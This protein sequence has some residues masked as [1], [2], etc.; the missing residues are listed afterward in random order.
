MKNLRYILLVG[1]GCLIISCDRFSTSLYP[2]YTVFPKERIVTTQ[3]IFVDSVFFRYPY[4]ITIKDNIAIVM[5]LHNDSYFFH[6][7]TY[8]GWELIAPFGKRGEGPE[9]MLSAEMFQFCSADSIWAI[10]ANKMQITRWAISLTEKT[11]SRVEEIAL[12]KNLVRSLDFYRTDYVFLITDYLGNYRYH[13]VSHRGNIVRSIGKIPTETN[14]KQNIYPALAQAWR[15]FTDYNSQN[16]VYA[17]VTQLGE[18]LEIYDL[19]RKTN[20]IVYGPNGEPQFFTENGGECIPSGIKGFT[21]V[22]VTDKYIYAVFD[23]LSWKER[24]A[25]RQRGEIPPQ[26]GH[27][28]YTFDFNGEPIQKYILDKNILGIHIDETT[29]TCFATCVESDNPILTF[30]L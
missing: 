19:K 20:T 21:D 3:E 1:L 24:N 18:V 29:S 30:K 2:R 28:V 8:P 4:R 7:F 14:H 23:G 17:M 10:D 6:S 22:Q 27:Y 16:G 5:D 25:F 11:V 26:G 12:D 15:S 9:E 13:E